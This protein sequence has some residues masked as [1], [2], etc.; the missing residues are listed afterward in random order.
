[1]ARSRVRRIVGPGIRFLVVLLALLLATRFLFGTVTARGM[2]PETVF[3]LLVLA[4]AAAL[5]WRASLNMRK[6]LRRLRA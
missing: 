6:A 2:G 4:T 1:M 5:L 3:A